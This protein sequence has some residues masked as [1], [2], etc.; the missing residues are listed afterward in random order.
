MSEMRRWV[1]LAAALGLFFAVYAG[2]AEAWAFKGLKLLVDTTIDVGKANDAKVNDATVTRLP[3]AL[4]DTVRVEF[5]VT[6]GAGKSTIGYD[7][8]FVNTG[9][10]FTDNFTILGVEGIIAMMGSPTTTGVTGASLSAAAVPANNYIATVSLRAKKAI[11]EGTKITLA[12]TTTMGDAATF[13]Q[14]ALDVT[15][16]VVTFQSPPKP[17]L[18]VTNVKPVIPIGGS[19]TTPITLSNLK[20]GD[21]IS[22]TIKITG[23]ATVEVNGAKVTGS[24]TLTIDAAGAT[25][26][27]TLKASGSGFA[28]VDV[29]GTVN[30]AALTALQLVFTEQVPVELSSFGGELVEDHVVLNWTT[31]SQTNN[32]G[33]RVLR[34]V[35]GER[36]EV[37]SEMITGAGASDLLLSHNLFD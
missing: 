28:T 16:A 5:F 22:L 14:D 12:A 10:V 15:S 23:A 4:G 20:A 25:Q 17:T 29:T 18:S 7:L 27:V 34:S 6:G 2:Q 31:A 37:V 26:T 35:D 32:A 3:A 33:W 24:T 36:Y 19:V 11:V 21:K 1:W 30:A 13:D 8:Q 9:N